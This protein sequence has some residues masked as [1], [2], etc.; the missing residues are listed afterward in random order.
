[1][2]EDRD[3]VVGKSFQRFVHISPKKLKPFLELVRYKTV[4][5]AMWILQGSN[6][7]RHANIVMKAIKSACASY[8]EKS[9]DP[10]IPDDELFISLIK[11]DRGPILKRW[12]AGSRGRPA[13]R[14]RRLCHIS[15]EVTELE[16]SGR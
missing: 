16:K 11:V 5:E 10:N 13:M 4:S 7:R 12:R 15:V 2:M 14:R 1:M 9:R 8:R 6:K 3:I